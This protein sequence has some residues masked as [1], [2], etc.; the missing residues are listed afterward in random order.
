MSLKIIVGG[1]TI[2]SILAVV[3][4]IY[5]I[6]KS[7]QDKFQPTNYSSSDQDRPRIITPELFFD[8]G[9]MKVKDIKETKFKIKNTGSKPLEL[10]NPSTSCGCIAGQIIYAGKTSNEFNMHSQ[11]NL[12]WEI[13]PNTEF[14]L[15]A[16]YRPSIMPQY[17]SVE[18]EIYLST[19]DPSQTKLVFKIKAFVE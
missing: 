10:Y 18:R 17:G 7:E 16:I 14:T 4:F 8:F 6:S 15:K 1:L 9:K 3:V 19:N 5:F 13:A 2:L 11:A 12:V